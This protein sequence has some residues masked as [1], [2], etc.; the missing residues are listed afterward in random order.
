MLHRGVK[1]V[2][3]DSHAYK[4]EG[5]T[6]S[7]IPDGCITVY[8]TDKEEMCVD[9]ELGSNADG[10]VEKVKAKAKLAA[11]KF[12]GL[13]RK[14][15]PNPKHMAKPISM[16]SGGEGFGF[17][18]TSWMTCGVPVDS[19]TS[20]STMR[21]MRTRRM[22]PKKKRKVR[23][24]IVRAKR[25]EIEGSKDQHDACERRQRTEG[26]RHDPPSRI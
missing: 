8:K 9:T 18:G 14:E 10:N 26:P 12:S 19:A 24:A 3:L 2:R 23:S 4:E 13:K 1:G 25:A 21:Q 7:V 6:H 5:S 16:E 17:S 15:L 22:R 20:A 11:A